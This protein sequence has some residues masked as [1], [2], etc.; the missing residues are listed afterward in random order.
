[1]VGGGGENHEHPVKVQLLGLR[2]DFGVA[3][4]IVWV[5]EFGSSS[6]S[7]GFG[8]RREHLCEVSKVMLEGW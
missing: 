2:A 7:Q 6:D 3:G 1:V 5:T 8:F 4:Q